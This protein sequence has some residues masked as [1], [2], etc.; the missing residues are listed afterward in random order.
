MNDRICLSTGVTVKNRV[1]ATNAQ[2]RAYIRVRSGSSSCPEEPL[3]TRIPLYSEESLGL[4]IGPVHSGFP[5]GLPLLSNLG[6]VYGLDKN[7]TTRIRSTG[8]WN[9]GK[10]M[11]SLRVQ[12]IKFR[13]GLP[14]E[15]F[16]RRVFL[17]RQVSVL[18]KFFVRSWFHRVAFTVGNPVVIWSRISRVIATGRAC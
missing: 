6:I 9:M 4:P 5:C 3:Q 14:A 15:G 7:P 8:L 17:I 12:W 18:S 16:N 2:I 10:K 1:P 11:G 13:V